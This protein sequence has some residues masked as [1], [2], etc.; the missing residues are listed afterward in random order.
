M[1]LEIDDS[2]RQLNLAAPQARQL[3]NHANY[4][5]E[6]LE[7]RN[8]WVLCVIGFFPHLP[9][10]LHPQVSTWHVFKKVGRHFMLRHVWQHDV[11]RLSAAKAPQD[12]SPPPAA[13]DGRRLPRRRLNPDDSTAR[14]VCARRPPR[15]TK[16]RVVELFCADLCDLELWSY[17]YRIGDNALVASLACFAAA[18]ARIASIQRLARGLFPIAQTREGTS[19]LQAGYPVQE[20]YGHARYEKRTFRIGHMTLELTVFERTRWED[21]LFG[22]LIEEEELTPA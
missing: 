8:E 20:S 13:H 14:A 9:E 10:I 6:A 15:S 12:D 3:F 11:W 18:K 16:K 21:W 17:L 2:V 1:P 22:R 19:K 5:V 4:L 7:R